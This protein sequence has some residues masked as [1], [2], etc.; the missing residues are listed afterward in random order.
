MAVNRHSKGGPRAA[1]R[2][3]RGAASRWRHDGSEARWARSDLRLRRI[4]SIIFAPVFTGGGT[5]FVLLALHATEHGEPSSPLCVVMAAVCF[6]MAAVA[7]IDLY[8]I[9]RR[10]REQQRW[11]RAV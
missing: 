10:A 8:V 5:V 2:R 11:H 9:N 3:A 6:V 4:L 7:L 1:D